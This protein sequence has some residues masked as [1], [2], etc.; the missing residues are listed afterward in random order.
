[1]LPLPPQKR[2][3]NE[4]KKEKR[5]MLSLTGNTSIKQRLLEPYIKNKKQRKRK[6][7]LKQTFVN[8]K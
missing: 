5:H 3:K 2:E 1:M 7:K 6:K 8:S 4:T